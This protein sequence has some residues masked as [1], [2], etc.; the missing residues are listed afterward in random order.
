MALSLIG[1]WVAMHLSGLVSVTFIAFRRP[2]LSRW[3]RVSRV[4]LCCVLICVLIFVL[5]HGVV[6]IDDAL[7]AAPVSS[8]RC[9]LLVEVDFI[10][11]YDTVI[12]S[13]IVSA[14][15]PVACGVVG[16]SAVMLARR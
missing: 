1:A 14:K 15:A 4:A 8:I 3:R 16:I 11:V 10:I 5:R 12:L 13:A 7:S 2:N 6:V 9:V